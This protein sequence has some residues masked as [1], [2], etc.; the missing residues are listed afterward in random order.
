MADAAEAAVE[1]AADRCL[2]TACFIRTGESRGSGAVAA[3]AAGMAQDTVSPRLRCCR[4]PGRIMS[5]HGSAVPLAHYCSPAHAAKHY[6]L[7]QLCGTAKNARHPES[8]GLCLPG[9]QLRSNRWWAK[10]CASTSNDGGGGKPLA[11]S[12][13]VTAARVVGHEGRLLPRAAYG[14]G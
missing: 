8:A 9:G 12:G 10:I 3:A 7:V 13:L 2:C 14:A 11:I 5:S 6:E 4:R 1:Q